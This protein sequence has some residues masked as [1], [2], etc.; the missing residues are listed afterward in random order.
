MWFEFIFVSSGFAIA[1]GRLRDPVV[2]E[3]LAA[4]FKKCCSKTAGKV[5]KTSFTHFEVEEKPL[6]DINKEA[7]LTGN[8]NTEIVLTIL[9]GITLLAA[10]SNDKIDHVEDSEYRDF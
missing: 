10:T 1:L 6:E 2:R 4:G 9:K 8:L 5:I 3:R 7:F